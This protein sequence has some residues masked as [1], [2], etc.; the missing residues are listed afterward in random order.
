MKTAGAFPTFHI[1]RSWLL[2]GAI[3]ALLPASWIAL[4][5]WQLTEAEKLWGYRPLGLHL[6]TY[7]G[8]SLLWLSRAPLTI[9]RWHDYLLSTC[10]GA[11]LGVTFPPSPIWPVV[12]FGIAALI[13]LIE[14]LQHRSLSNSFRCLVHAFMLW[15]I[16]AT[17]WIS[18]TAFAAGIVAMTANTLLMCIPVLLFL[19]INS[20]LQLKTPMLLLVACWI[21]FEFWHFRWEAHWPWL[22]IGHYLMDA[23]L[24]CQWYEFTGI[25]GGSLWLWILAILLHRWYTCGYHRRLM[26]LSVLMMIIPIAASV[27]LWNFRLKA[28]D[29][30][31][32][33]GLVNLNVEP[34]YARDRL[35]PQAL[36]ARFDSLSQPILSQNLDV[37]VFPETT[38][39]LRLNDW[40]QVAPM[41]LWSRLHR[42][43]PDMTIISGLESYRVLDEGEPHDRYTRTYKV[44]G[45]APVYW[46]SHN[47]AIRF[48]DVDDYDLYY[49]SMLVP[50]AEFFPMRKIF[51]FLKPLMDKLGGSASGLR[52]QEER[53]VF[54]TGD[55]GAAPVICYESVFGEYVSAYVHAGA[56]YLV[57]MTND[58]WWDDT[59]GYR[60]HL[61]FSRLRAIEQR[62]WIARAANMGTCG[63]INTRGEI[64]QATTYDQPSAIVGQIYPNS[65]QTLYNRLGDLL[66]RLAILVVA[67]GICMVISKLLMK[68]GVKEKSDEK[69]STAT[70]LR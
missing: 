59:A 39:S 53:S 38:W 62:K 33:V 29:Q 17:Y 64:L 65:I 2:Y 68:R 67:G 56:D 63:F 35:T 61:G 25:L 22:A 23:P 43:Q 12:V 51:F 5:M 60:Q 27:Y 20:I 14:R 48:K 16:I 18:N 4:S 44:S 54:R 11:L 41:P 10:T 31:L 24:L 21:S 7:V 46:E 58:G 57:V 50:G 49:K 69:R 1:N 36:I 19:R 15:N 28:T 40:P 42:Q 66:G 3:I 70:H 9:H 32:T 6:C 45:K 26:W 47:S 52:K 55:H 37:L 34:H 13:S 8:L 30:A